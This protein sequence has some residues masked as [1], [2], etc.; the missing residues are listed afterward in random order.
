MTA[1]IDISRKR[2]DTKRI[3]FV[4]KSGGKAVNISSWTAFKLTVDPSKEPID[5]TTL[6]EQMTGAL[7]AGGGDGRVH[8]LPAGTIPAGGYFYDAQALDANGEKVTFA[9]GKYKVSQDITKG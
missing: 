9:E 1:S 3:V 2:G 6:A 5:A 7:T 8:F 4:I